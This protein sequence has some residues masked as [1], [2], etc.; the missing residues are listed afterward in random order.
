M[1]IRLHSALFTAI[2]LTIAAADVAEALA[3]PSKLEASPAAAELP[4]EVKLPPHVEIAE[5]DRAPAVDERAVVF[6]S[7]AAAANDA[8]A[9]WLI[10][11]QNNAARLGRA[12][13]SRV[14]DIT[15]R[16]LHKK[17]E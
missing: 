5:R 4:V 13:A 1:S 8:D 16:M 7:V 6:V 15:S 14:V 2:G 12:E 11:Q 3:T 17:G 9:W 10:E